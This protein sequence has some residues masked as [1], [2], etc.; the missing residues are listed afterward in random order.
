VPGEEQF[1]TYDPLPLMKGIADDGFVCI[2]ATQ[3]YAIS[4][5]QKNASILG[6]PE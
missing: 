5:I 3:K 2:E 6:K 4:I 1:K